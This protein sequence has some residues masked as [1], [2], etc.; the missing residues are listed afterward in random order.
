M[1]FVDSHC[2][3]N[4]L[5]D[6]PE[7]IARARAANVDTMLCIGVEADR[8]S[9][10]LE[11]ADGNSGIWASVGEHPGNASGRPK[12]LHDHL[13][14]PRI[15][16]IG[17]TG[18]DYFY[19]ADDATRKLQLDG[20]RYQMEVAHAE[21]LPVIIHTRAAVEDTLSV[22]HEFP[23]VTGVLHCF[24]ENWDM[25]EKALALG[26]YI[27]ISGIV[28]FKNAENVRDVA[29][30]VPSERLLIETD[31]PWLAPVPNRGK[32]NEPAF[33]A[34]TAQYVADLRGQTLAEIAVL[35]RDNFFRLFPRADSK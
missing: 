17:E 25:A 24:T 28:T 7:A 21:N 32:T 22:L 27:S 35:T 18:L 12:W 14:H 29:R 23:R 8:F 4:Y 30:R 19:D 5:D 31:A 10:V 16:A 11:C 1:Q 34:H 3:L 2:H 26:Y 20:F 15:V 13:P 9:E 33:V 6:T